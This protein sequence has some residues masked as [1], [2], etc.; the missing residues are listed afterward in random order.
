V[1]EQIAFLCSDACAFV[2]GAAVVLDG[3][4][5]IPGSRNV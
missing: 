3:G 5:T 4:L 2:T 1:A